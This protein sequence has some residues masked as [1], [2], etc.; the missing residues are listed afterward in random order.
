MVNAGSNI[1][2]TTDL[3]KESFV[4]PPNKN[5]DTQNAPHKKM[6]S[7]KPDM[8]YFKDLFNALGSERPC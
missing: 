4:H 5:T 7:S 2:C 3:N 8:R 1:R 6:E